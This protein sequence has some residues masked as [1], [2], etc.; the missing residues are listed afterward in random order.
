M[1]ARGGGR[2][3]ILC[4]LLVACATPF[5]AQ[6]PMQPDKFST[7]GNPL[8]GTPI[9]H[10]E[11]AVLILTV[12]GE[13]HEVLDRQSVIKL[14]DTTTHTTLWQ[15][16]T[17]QSEA[18]FGDLSVGQY[19]IEASAV[20][21]LS[22]TKPYQVGSGYATYH[23]EISLQRDPNAVEI[24]EPNA[25]DLSKKARKEI[26]R[27]VRALKSGNL[28]NAQKKLQN[29]SVL[30]PNSADVNFLLGY[31]YFLKQDFHQA[32]LFLAKASTEDSHNVQVLTLLGR[33]RLHENNDIAA[34]GTLEEAIATDPEYWLAHKFLA[35]AYLKEHEFDKSRAQC[36]IAIAKSKGAGASVDLIL[37]PAL[38]DLG[39]TEEAISTLNDFLRSAPNKADAEQAR[40]LIKLIQVSANTPAAPV[41]VI[42][43]PESISDDTDL[44]LSVKSWLPPGIDEEKPSVAA[45]VAC[46]TDKVITESGF[47]VEQFASNISKFAA[48][49]DLVHERV[50]ELGHAIT[51][52]TRKYN[53]VAEISETKPGYLEV[54]EFR[55][56]NSQSS[57]F[58][59]KEFPDNMVTNG[60]P[61][62]AL[63]FH[64]DMR[65]N[66]E[67][68]CEGLG[69]LQGQ[70]TW[71]VHFRQRDD[72]PNRIH[73][74]K[75]GGVIYPVNLKGRAWISAA[76]FQVVHIEAELIKPMPN[77]QL[78]TEREI[79][80]Y[81][82]VQFKAK[83]TELWLPIK[84][85]LY[86]D[87]RKHRY[88]RQH[89]FN[90]FML[91]S[92]DSED[93][94][95]GPKQEPKLKDGSQK[96]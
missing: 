86:F 95:S 92:T 9:Y 89:S 33:V 24:K 76:T 7:T 5:F 83:S 71:L 40:N 50:D 31:L 6:P 37:A 1:N 19:N 64:P 8:S 10:S 65:D 15:T 79:V 58:P 69:E 82:P 22:A 90:H 28:K 42:P 63:V 80:D 88:Y 49:E 59:D 16:T 91:F 30:A 27:G 26:Q 94:V 2:S 70:A 68:V 77:I 13:K 87:F 36:E 81:G 18:S 54:E 4:C 61:S 38:A 23:V 3:A 11:G 96:N 51:K 20:G 39:K 21:Y 25:P 53:Y 62:L 73:E 29:A 85:D 67:F 72:R 35:I 93:K 60:F 74:F 45:G 55:T 78:L 44:R 34:R 46:P 47:K 43:A 48:I 41:T 52:E 84:A 75:V 32:Q 12:V 56:E 17:D 57:E 66:F 14:E